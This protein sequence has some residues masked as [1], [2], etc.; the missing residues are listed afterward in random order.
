MDST[1]EKNFT[2]HFDHTD[3]LLQEDPYPVFRELR[4]KCPVAHS[5]AH[6]GFWVVSRYEDVFQIAHEHE[7]YSSASG[8]TPLPIGTQRPMIPIEVDPP[9][10]KRYRTLL[11][12]AFTPEAIAKLEYRRFHPQGS[13]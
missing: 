10:H 2:E 7:T 9:M 11:N 1:K 6:D 13:V 5:D 12:P 3:P 8:I 4:E